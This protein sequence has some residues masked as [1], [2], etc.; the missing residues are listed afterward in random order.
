MLLLDLN[1]HIS[2][3][4]ILF[5]IFEFFKHLSA[6]KEQIFRCKQMYK[7]PTDPLKQFVSKEQSIC[8]EN[9]SNQDLQCGM[10]RESIFSSTL[11]GISKSNYGYC[12]LYN[13]R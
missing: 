4:F 7:Q 8:L 6:E 1:F 12:K 9:T 2:L 3:K 5:G 13:G 10:M 11:F